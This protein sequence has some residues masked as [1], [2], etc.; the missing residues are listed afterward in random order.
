MPSKE[1][2]AKAAPPALEVKSEV[3]EQLIQGPLTPERLE[4]M[5][6]G[7]KIAIVKRTLG[8]ELTH[9][10]GYAK[11]EAP[12][13]VQSNRRNGTRLKTVLTDGGSLDLAIARDRE[14][15]FGP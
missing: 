1:R 13:A 9:Q 8:A 2:E 7:V 3:F 6:R 12:P 5:I 15:S 14:V 10:L 4:R 11:G